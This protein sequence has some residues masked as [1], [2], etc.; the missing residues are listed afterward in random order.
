MRACPYICIAIGSGLFG[1]GMGHIV[2]AYAL[3]DAIHLKK[4]LEIEKHDERNILIANKAKGRA[5]EVMTF[6]FSALM[7]SFALMGIDMIA[8]L[9]LVFAYL[10]VQA[11][12]IYYRNK[13]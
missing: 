12:A 6:V 3:K 9:L 7:L 10:F 11:S 4:Q 2:S 13:V 5:F 1:Q 8:V